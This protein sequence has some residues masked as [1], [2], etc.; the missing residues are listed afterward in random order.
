MGEAKIQL[1]DKGVLL[2]DVAVPSEDAWKFLMESP[3]EEWEPRLLRAI[4]IGVWALQRALDT[5]SMDFIK[6][7]A[8]EIL[9]GVEGK[10]AA[11]P[12]DIESGLRDKLGT[13][14]GQLLAPI[15]ALITNAKTDAESVI[16]RVK[17]EVEDLYTLH[18]DPEQESSSLARKLQIIKDLLDS[19]KDGS[20]Q[21]ELKAAVGM[22]TAAD[23]ALAQNVKSLVDAALAPFK[24]EID[25]ITA[26]ITQHDLITGIV[27]RTTLKGE[28]FQERVYEELLRAFGQSGCIV[29]NIGGDNKTGDV[30]LSF[31]EG[32]GDHKF[33]YKIIVEAKEE[34]GNNKGITDLNRI[35][36]AAMDRRA[37]DGAAFIAPV[38]AFTNETRYWH[39]G[40]VD[41]GPWVSTTLENAVEAVRF[42][43]ITL[44][45]ERNG[46]DGEVDV[47]GAAK[48]LRVIKDTLRK[49]ADVLRKL[50]DIETA[51]DTARGLVNDMHTSIDDAATALEGS[52]GLSKREESGDTPPVAGCQ[53]CGGPIIRTGGRGR[54]PLRCANCR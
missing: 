5:G 50:R 32:A 20:V 47:D 25:A 33:A 10:L 8:K 43:R 45:L 1:I 42:L 26:K 15:N 40:H 14:E 36:S 7:Q 2:Q 31:T 21:K 44:H 16:R 22:V 4:E 18:L 48:Q 38:E 34:R 13:A 52:L 9:G 54:P 23:G 27:E 11:L 51:A 37:A 3:E 24:E 29:E 53:V 39:Q 30:L 41:R 17:Q 35:L 19:T 46:G 49:K 12:G 28:S 6:N